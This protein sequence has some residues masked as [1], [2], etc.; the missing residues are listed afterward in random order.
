MCF[1]LERTIRSINLQVNTTE[2]NKEKANAINKLIPLPFYSNI[3]KITV[4]KKKNGYKPRKKPQKKR[5]KDRS[6]TLS[7]R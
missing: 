5:A 3:R 4:Q 6:N 1:F 7:G 2:R